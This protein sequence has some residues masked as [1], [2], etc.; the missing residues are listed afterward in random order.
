MKC[1]FIRFKQIE[2]EISQTLQFNDNEWHVASITV[3]Q[4]PTKMIF[5]Q[6]DCVNINLFESPNSSR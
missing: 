4:E 1:I 5:L 2:I 6:V 3:L